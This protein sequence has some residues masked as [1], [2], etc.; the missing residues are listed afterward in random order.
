MNKPRYCRL[1]Y[2]PDGED[3]PVTVWAL[4]GP[5]TDEVVQTF[6]ECDEYGNPGDPIVQIVTLVNEATIEPAKLTLIE[7]GKR[8]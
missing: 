8:K 7:E 4:I 2:T 3:K 6:W 5:V 1:T